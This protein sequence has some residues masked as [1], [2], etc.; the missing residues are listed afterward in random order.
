MPEKCM[1]GR[2]GEMEGL[3]INPAKIASYN[4]GSNPSYFV[5]GSFECVIDFVTQCQLHFLSIYYEKRQFSPS[6]GYI[7]FKVQLSDFGS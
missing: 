1:S 6:L 2:I 5:S 4:N 3:E 7:Y